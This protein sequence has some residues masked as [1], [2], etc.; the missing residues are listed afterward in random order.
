MNYLERWAIQSDS[1]VVESINKSNSI[2]SRAKHVIFCLKLGG[3]P[4][5]PK[6]Y[7]LTDSAQVP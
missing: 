4:S 6:Y 1:L 3:P 7:C 2:L 5:N